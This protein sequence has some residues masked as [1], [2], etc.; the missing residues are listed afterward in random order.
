MTT[1]LFAPK[2]TAK[3][4]LYEWMKSQKRYIKT[5]EIIRYGVE[6]YSNRADRNARQLAQEGKIKRIDDQL[7][8]MIFN[9]IKEDVWEVL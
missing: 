4:R 6:N 2:L 8:R 1:D 9:K 5:S 7:K 3:D